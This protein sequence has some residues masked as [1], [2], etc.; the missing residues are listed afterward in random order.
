MGN[1]CVTYVLLYAFIAF[2]YITTV[3]SRCWNLQH[4]QRSRLRFMSQI[5]FQSSLAFPSVTL[6]KLKG[7]RCQ[8]ISEGHWS[9]GSIWIQG[10]LNNR[11]L[12]IQLFNFVLR[13]WVQR[14]GF[15][16]IHPT[17]YKSGQTTEVLRRG[18][19]QCSLAEG[20]RCWKAALVLDSDQQ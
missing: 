3:T 16:F 6:K 14:D 19:T 15:V 12:H 13:D 17:D 5:F 2:S 11:S 10:N 9:F 8:K 4:G 20:E 18:I 7:R 1:S